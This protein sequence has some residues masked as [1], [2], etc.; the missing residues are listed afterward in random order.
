MNR[1]RIV[2]FALVAGVGVVG[3]GAATHRL[4]VANDRH[5]GRHGGH[6]PLAHLC[7]GNNSDKLT[8]VSE[9]LSSELDL[10]VD[11]SQKWDAVTEVVQSSDFAALCSAIPEVAD[12]AI[13]KLE[14][15]ET[16]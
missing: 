16:T 10:T 1:N 13:A 4:A 3:L 8:R 2:T 6:G 11:Q 14:Q 5:Q 9:Y 7:D 15:L 12:T